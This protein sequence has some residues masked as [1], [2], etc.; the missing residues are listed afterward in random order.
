MP[1]IDKIG[2]RNFI[3]IIKK[4]NKFKQVTAQDLEEKNSIAEREWIVEKVSTL[5]EKK[6]KQGQ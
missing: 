1:N 4:M 5:N 6:K 2:Y 3:K